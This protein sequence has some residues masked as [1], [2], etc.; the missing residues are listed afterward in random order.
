MNNRTSLLLIVVLAACLAGV[1]WGTAYTGAPVVIT[2]PNGAATSFNYVSDGSSARTD[3]TTWWYPKCSMSAPYSKSDFTVG[4]VGSGYLLGINFW[5]FGGEIGDRRNTMYN[6]HELWTNDAGA[7]EFDPNGWY[8]NSAYFFQYN[9][10]AVDHDFEGAEN[11]FFLVDSASD[12]YTTG[13]IIRVGDDAVENYPDVS[14]GFSTVVTSGAVQPCIDLNAKDATWA[15]V[16]V[17][18]SNV[19]FTS[20]K[21]PEGSTTPL[22]FKIAKN[23]SEGTVP[24][25][26]LDLRTALNDS[27]IKDC[28]GITHDSDGNLYVIYNPTGGVCKVAKFGP[29]PSLTLISADFINVTNHI[30]YYDIDSIDDGNSKYLFLASGGTAPA[31]G[32]HQYLTN[33]TFVRTIRSGTAITAIEVL[34]IPPHTQVITTTTFTATVN[35]LGWMG[36]SLPTVSVVVDGGA[37]V[38]KALTAVDADTGTFTINLPN[39]GSHSVKVKANV[40]LS[41]TQSGTTPAFNSATFN[42]QCGDNTNDNVIDDFDFNNVITNFGSGAGG[43]GNG[44]A[45]TDD[46]DF[47]LVITNFGAAGS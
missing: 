2:S 38:T 31:I 9:F 5:N 16:E 30:A 45:A 35:L 23:F 14:P 26:L 32:C 43:D 37:P 11:A 12:S 19:Y 10:C 44:D 47:N 15:D 40:T 46:F 29:E 6:Y 21:G 22:V 3:M 41:Q 7:S 17:Y 24:T 34:P 20:G 8:N 25:T 13:K 28:R 33:G 39:T 18:G 1:A 27:L 42:L 36:A 4:S